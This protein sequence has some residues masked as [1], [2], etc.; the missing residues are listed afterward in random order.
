MATARVRAHPYAEPVSTDN[1]DEEGYLTANPDV[2]AAV[3]DGRLSSGREHFDLIGH[4]EGRQVWRKSNILAA[5]A[6][7]SSRILVELMES[8]RV[9]SVA[10]DG[11]IHCLPDELA[12]AAGVLSTDA[13]SSNPYDPSI[14]E[15]IDANPGRW[16]L[17][18][19]SGLRSTYYENVV[20]LDIVAYD[21]TDVLAVGE[22]LPFRAD[23]FDLVVSVAVLEHVRDPF[24]CAAELYR[25]L[26]PGG[27]LFVAV[28]FLQPFHGY[29]DHYYNM[30]SS[31]VRNLF[32]EP[33]IAV[34]QFVPHYFQPLWVVSWLFKLWSAGLPEP[35]V[36]ALMSVTVRDLVS[37]TVNDYEQPWVR[38]LDPAT[39]NLI[40]SGTVLR[41]RKPG[42]PDTGRSP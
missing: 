18:A 17:D 36:E 21:T 33:L 22:V 24:R 14:L 35:A 28:P 7:K 39:A 31:G 2:A 30:T 13:V 11:L 9:E 19:G 12:A 16:I 20:N 25:V 41:A 10:P 26:K 23:V 40:S 5:K 8:T 32:R 1:F 42:G 6:V 27:E 29:P 38:D 3:A 37:A 4:G 15:F 34:D